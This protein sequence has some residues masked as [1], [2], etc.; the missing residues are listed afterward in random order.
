MTNLQKFFRINNQLASEQR[1]AFGDYFIGALSVL[2]EA[3]AWPSTAR[4]SNANAAPNGR[5]SAKRAIRKTK[6]GAADVQAW[7]S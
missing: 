2:A 3:K 7:R 6:K 4:N 1:E 5:A